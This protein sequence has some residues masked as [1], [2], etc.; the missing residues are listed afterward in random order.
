[1]AEGSALSIKLLYGTVLSGSIC[2]DLNHHLWRTGP[3]SG[4]MRGSWWRR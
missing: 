3:G 1:M 4:A 2:F